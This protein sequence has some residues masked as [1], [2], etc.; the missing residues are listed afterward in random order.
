MNI[1]ILSLFTH[2]HGG[3]GQTRG[4]RLPELKEPV[5]AIVCTLSLFGHRSDMRPEGAHGGCVCACDC[6]TYSF[7]RLTHLPL[8]SPP[9]TIMATSVSS[10]VSHLGKPSR[11]R[12]VMPLPAPSKKKI[13]VKYATGECNGLRCPHLHP[14]DPV[15][16]LRAAP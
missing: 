6:D 16:H 11:C 8:S 10:R 5:F 12:D 15:S 9:T 1:N 13:C 7:T 14:K 2:G 3:R 4:Q